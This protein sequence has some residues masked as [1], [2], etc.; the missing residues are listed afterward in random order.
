MYISKKINKD[1]LQI[2]ASSLSK[3][4]VLNNLDEEI[5]HRELLRLVSNSH[6]YQ[7]LK[8]L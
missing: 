5:L 6:T 7:E 2:E 8:S 3:G 1:L 4:F